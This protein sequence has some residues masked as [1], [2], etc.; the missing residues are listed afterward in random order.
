MAMVPPTFRDDS[1]GGKSA[2]IASKPRDV[3]FV[4]GMLCFGRLLPCEADARPSN[5]IADEPHQFEQYETRS[6]LTG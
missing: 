4:A 1:L 3:P 2:S 5:S 6:V